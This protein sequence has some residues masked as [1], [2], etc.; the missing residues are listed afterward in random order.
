M[1]A[2]PGTRSAGTPEA[3]RQKKLSAAAAASRS[4]GKKRGGGGRG[5][6]LETIAEEADEEVVEEEA[7]AAAVGEEA[8]PTASRATRSNLPPTAGGVWRLTHVVKWL[9][10]TCLRL[11]RDS[12]TCHDHA[13]NGFCWG[14]ATLGAFLPTLVPTFTAT[15][16]PFAN[17]PPKATGLDRK[18]EAMTRDHVFAAVPAPIAAPDRVARGARGQLPSVVYFEQN[19][20]R[21]PATG[22]QRTPVLHQLPRVATG[23]LKPLSSMHGVGVPWHWLSVRHSLHAPLT[24]CR[25]DPRPCVGNVTRLLDRRCHT[26]PSAVCPCLPSGSSLAMSLTMHDMLRR[27]QASS[28]KKGGCWQGIEA[29]GFLASLLKLRCVIHV[30]CDVREPLKYIGVRGTSLCMHAAPAP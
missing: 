22:R 3:A 13:A 5:K 14:S 4:K 1:V 23:D 2:M 11:P 12:W 27:A 15:R 7:A 6:P 25:S 10:E 18:V 20:S 28:N 8:A 24:L 17:P 9:A 21:A 30:K 19:P 26:A 16:V 29:I